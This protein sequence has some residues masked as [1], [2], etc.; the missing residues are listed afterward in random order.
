MACTQY[1]YAFDFFG[2]FGEK[3]PK[4]SQQKLPYMLQIGS[5]TTKSGMVQ[6]IQDTSILYKL[7][8]EAPRDGEELVRRAEADL[9]RIIDTMWG[10]GHYAAKV[11][12]QIAGVS[13][14]FGRPAPAS[15]ARQAERSR[16]LSL[17]PVRIKL[18]PGPLYR[19]GNIDIVDAATGQP[20]PPGVLPADILGSTEGGPARTGA[21]VALAARINRHFR[22]K[23]HP[24]A[25]VVDPAPVINHR[26]RL[27]AIKL[28]IK[29]GPRA[30]IGQIRVSGTRKV[31]QRMVRSFI[32]VEPGVL[33]SPERLS[34][35]RKSISKIEAIG[36]VK[37]KPADRLDPDGS[38]PLDV[39]VTERLPRA[40]GAAASYST[41]DGP[42]I[43]TYWTHRNLF[44]GA[45]RL[46]L[47]ADFFY[48]TT[49]NKSIVNRSR[50]FDISNFGGRVSASF[51]KP[52]LG[53][54]RADFL[55][56][57][58]ILRDRTEGYTTTLANAVAAIRY[59]FADNAWVQAGVEGE[60][61]K[62]LDVFGESRYHLL[63][64]PISASWDTTDNALDPKRG[65]RIAAN[66]TPY[67]GFGD[68]APIFVASKLV[69][70]AYY[71]LDE[72]SRFILAARVAV[73]S[74]SGG[75]VRRIPANRRLFAGGGGSVRG[76]AYK[77]LGPR[78]AA[79]QLIGGLSLFEASLEARIKI[80]NTIGI[81]PLIDVGNAFAKAIPD[82]SDLRIGAGLG[83]RYYTAIGPIRV[84]FAVPINRRRGESAFAVYFSV[85]QA[86]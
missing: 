58:H 52:A 43:K 41:V 14:F 10:Y 4:V 37:V 17:V 9:P 25:E 67:K 45:E 44:G 83:L 85:G 46:R 30:P 51:I 57:A 86:F 6:A 78:N 80:T 40:L 33:Y 53:G 23:G 60:T 68:A 70:S 79:G 26:T 55:A 22:R 64:L 27:V 2:L 12:I 8:L 39:D 73:S 18:A 66:V 61:G 13:L 5:K 74:I 36:S 28:A 77:S 35:M 15:A 69:A 81:V 84:D 7:R 24:Y 42:S 62:T 47:A 76:F 11:S 75:S 31:P 49:S 72:K 48:L 71:S 3:P 19:F 63:G 59:R 16:S 50:K 56:D 32:Y 34:E 82:F 38:V 1:S 20:F 29:P 21:L 54:T 65:F